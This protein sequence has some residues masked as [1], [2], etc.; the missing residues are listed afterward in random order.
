MRSPISGLNQD[1]DLNWASQWKE[2]VRNSNDAAELVDTDQDG[3]LD[4]YE[5][6]NKSDPDDSKSSPAIKL[7]SLTKKLLGTDNDA[8]GLPNRL[9]ERLGT[10]IDNADSDEDGTKDGA[11]VI[12]GAN[13][14]VYGFFGPDSDGD[15]LSDAYETNEGLNPQSFDTDGDGLRD[16]DEIALA[17]NP[18]SIDTDSDGITDGRELMLGGH[19]SIT[20]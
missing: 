20:D 10:D 9:E 12:S 1:A 14:T 3:F 16:D 19:P 15:G 4:W 8:D 17:A 5:I 13:P 7:G 6:N 2:Q 11:E 18:F